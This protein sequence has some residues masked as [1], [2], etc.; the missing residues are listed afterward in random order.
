MRISVQLVKVEDGYPLWSETYDRTLDD[1]FAVQDDIAQSVVKELRTTL[2]GEAPDSDASGDVQADV[3]K[4]AHGRSENPEA[5]RLYL[6]GTHFL[7]QFTDDGIKNGIAALE[8]AVALDPS[9]ALAWAR[10]AQLYATQGAYGWTPVLEGYRKAR[11]AVEHALVLAPDLPEAHLVLSNIQSAHDW[12]YRAAEAS[13]R[14]ALELAPGNPAALEVV[15][16]LL[17]RSGRTEEAEPLLLKAAE[18]NPLSSRNCGNIAYMYR[19]LHRWAEAESWYRKSL[20]LAPGRIGTHN[21][22]ASLMAQ[23]GRDAEARGR[24]AARAGRMGPAHGIRGRP[25]AGRAARGIRC[26]ARG[27]DREACRRERVPDRRRA[28]GA[29]RVRGSLPVARPGDRRSRRRADAPHDG[30]DVRAAARRSAL[31]RHPAEDRVRGLT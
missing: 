1:I 6:Q 8:A 26:G 28:H 9:Y 7:E 17:A 18:L 5:H 2:M 3:A 12:D 30:A 24:G 21:M 15:G 14:R 16:I 22:I 31:A 19:T 4:A 25:L 10:L 27:V 20:E 29:R 23:Q 11:G 13:A